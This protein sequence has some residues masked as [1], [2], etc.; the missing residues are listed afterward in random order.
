[1]DKEA[2]ARASLLG[3]YITKTTPKIGIVI[4][5][6]SASGMSRR[7][8]VINQDLYDITDYIA[9]LLDLSANDKGLLIKG[10]GMD[11]TFWLANAIAHRLWSDDN[12]APEWAYANGSAG[13]CLQWQVI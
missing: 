13:R 5:S 10:C 3:H 4:K 9:D 11:M 8:K 7:M 12:E 6:V 1:M 2:N